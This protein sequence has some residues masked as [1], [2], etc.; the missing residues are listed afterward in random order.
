MGEGAVDQ[1]VRG[2]AESPCGA[3]ILGS[4]GL[5]SLIP[6]DRDA[7]SATPERDAPADKD[8]IRNGST[9][10]AREEKREEYPPGL[11]DPLRTME[12][13]TSEHRRL[14]ALISRKLELGLRK[15]DP[16]KGLEHLK[17]VKLAGDI[18]S[19]VVRGQR[20]AWGL[21]AIE[22]ELAPNDTEE[23]I[24]EMACLTAPLR[25]DAALERG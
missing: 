5:G 11:S 20:Q 23:I 22:A 10:T 15:R 18:L 7:P 3:D 17:A 14:W 8:P 4:P 16:K 21:E 13:I 6:A 19:V 1:A 9:E 25:A 12:T 24:E 2:V